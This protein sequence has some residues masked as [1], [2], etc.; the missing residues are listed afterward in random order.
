VE[1]EHAQKEAELD[2]E[3]KQ[4]WAASLALKRRFAPMRAFTAAFERDVN[5]VGREG[6][7]ERGGER[8]ILFCFV[9]P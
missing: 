6:A 2:A 8:N 7:S 9:E 3:R 4:I 5:K 1:T